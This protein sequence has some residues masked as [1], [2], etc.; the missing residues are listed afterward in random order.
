MLPVFFV[1]F[2]AFVINI[3][4]GKASIVFGWKGLPLLGD[5]AEFLLL[6]FAMVVFVIAALLRE[7]TG[8][9]DGNNQP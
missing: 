4:L 6:L 9:R 2:I 3:L 1:C 5:V 7:Q 8:K